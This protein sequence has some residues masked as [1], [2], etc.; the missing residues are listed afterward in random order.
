M[1]IP[2]GDLHASAISLLAHINL[3]GVSV[4]DVWKKDAEHTSIGASV[5]S[6]CF[7]ARFYIG[8]G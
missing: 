1:Q 8:G 3:L 6:L 2:L 4:P 7:R 5:A